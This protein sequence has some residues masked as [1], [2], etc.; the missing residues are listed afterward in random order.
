MNPLIDAYLAGSILDFE[1]V[2]RG[3]ATL[4]AITN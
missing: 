2:Q 3:R 1:K 4:D